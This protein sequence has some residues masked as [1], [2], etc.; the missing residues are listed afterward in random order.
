MTSSRQIVLLL[1][2]ASVLLPQICFCGGGDAPASERLGY[3]RS[4]EFD[5]GKPEIAGVE[6]DKAIYERTGSFSGIRV[7]DS[8]LSEIPFRISRMFVRK[9]SSRRVRCASEV[10]SL[11]KL[12]DNRIELLV[13]NLDPQKIPRFLTFVT[14]S[15]DYDKQVTVTAGSSTEDWGK[16]ADEQSIFDYSSIYGLSS[17]TVD[18]PS[19]PPGPYYK[20]LI[21]NFSESRQGKRIEMVEESREGKDYSQITKKILL[22]DDLRIKEVVLEAL[23]TVFHND[24]PVTRELETVTLSNSVADKSNEV[25][26]ETFRQPVTT[27]RIVPESKNFSRKYQILA[28]DDKEKWQQISAGT[29]SS[30]SI[31]GLEKSN[32]SCEFPETR[33]KYLKLLVHN[34]DAPELRISQIVCSGPVYRA[35]FIPPENTS[36][37]KLYYSGEMPPPRYDIEDIFAKIAN[38]AVTTLKLGTESANPLFKGP[39]PPSFLESKTILYV[40]IVVMLAV[41]AMAL[42]KA[43]SKI[44]QPKEENTKD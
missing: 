18:L 24:F 31:Q 42:M 2:A 12:D 27:L 39:R 35:E 10:V 28:S 9:Q 40:V 17:N 8:N 5:G 34:A 6:L 21:S 43:L 32:L 44:E 33:K 15:S 20:V 7:L 1:A 3:C 30:I 22:N 25:V 19:D 11:K 37:I 13:K 29:I 26:I 36:G 23:E 41:L 14:Q 38:P 16:S 4:V